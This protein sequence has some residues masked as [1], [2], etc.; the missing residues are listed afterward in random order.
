M[1]ATIGVIGPEDSVKR[2]MYVAEE[3]KDIQFIP[4][5]YEDLE[6]IRSILLDHRTEVDQWFFSGVLNYS[7]AIDNQL[8]TKEEASFPP[9]HGSSFFGVLLEAQL[10]SEKVFTKVSIDTVSTEEFEKVLSFNRL[11]KL[12]YYNHPFEDFRDPDKLA[13]SH[14]R[15]FEQ[16]KT[17]VVITSIKSVYYNLKEY[18]VPVYRVT[19]SYLSIR[20]VIQYLEER[21]QS[22]RYRNSQVAIIGCRVQFDLVK[23]DELYY[24][25]KMKYQE[26]DLRR[27]LLQISEKSRGS[28]MQLGDGLFFIFTTRGE[29]SEEAYLDLFSLIEEV[30]LQA[31]VDAIISIGFGETVSQAEQN[32]QLGFQNRPNKQDTTIIQV[33][34][35]QSI[36]LHDESS[37]ISYQTVE[38]G[39][40][41][42]EK[43]KHA[44]I[45]PGVVSK[46]LAYAKQY[47]RLEFTSQDLSRW[48]N[49]T[50]RNGRRILTE[51][52]KSGLVEQCGE[53][54]S[55]ERGRPRKV[56]TFKK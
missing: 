7:F 53:A 44:A 46:I 26:L 3:F 34:E 2:I 29:L 14:K 17:E 42:K 38:T 52:E 19:P 11:N 31:N 13:E 51:M 10:V 48:L 36:T 15:L 45:S 1:K 22:K 47:H 5:V 18:G 30:K 28:L 24:S 33:D 55:G 43:I 4:Y 41:W 21:A 9:L 39:D 56:Y 25:F 20:M 12:V 16:D 27:A 37:Q 8:V 32:V 35:D 49:S 54:Q 23:L 6:E 40:A 50:E